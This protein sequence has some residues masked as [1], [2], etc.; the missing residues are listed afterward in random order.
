MIRQLGSGNL[1]T[2]Q[3]ESALTKLRGSTQVN[4]C[5]YEKVIKVKADVAAVL[6][7]FRTNQVLV[8]CRVESV[9]ESPH[10]KHALRMAT[11]GR[12]RGPANEFTATGR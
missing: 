2:D 11:F 1:R 8:A 6:N 12:L 3:N 7:I 10:E 4:E 5:F 9:T